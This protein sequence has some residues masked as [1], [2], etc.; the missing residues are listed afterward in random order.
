MHQSNVSFV[1]K[2]KR[3]EIIFK[4]FVKSYLSCLNKRPCAGRPF[5]HDFFRHETS[6]ILPIPVRQWAATVWRP[7]TNYTWALVKNKV[8]SRLY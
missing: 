4:I 2:E 5:V 7:K 1:Y 8:Q 3:E 6:P